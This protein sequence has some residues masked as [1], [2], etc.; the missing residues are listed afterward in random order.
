[1]IRRESK[2]TVCHIPTNLIIIIIIK[3]HH[4]HLS[5]LARGATGVGSPESLTQSWKLPTSPNVIRL[6]RLRSP[7]HRTCSFG[8]VQWAQRS[9]FPNILELY[10]DVINS[11]IKIVV[12]FKVADSSANSSFPG[13]FRPMFGQQFEV[14]NSSTLGILALDLPSFDERLTTKMGCKKDSL[15]LFSSSRSSKSNQQKH[16]NRRF[17][18][19]KSCLSPDSLITR[20]RSTVQAH[21]LGEWDWLRSDWWI[22]CP[23]FA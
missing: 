8:S 6:S 14:R 2:I 19:F 11:F 10:D 12:I 22:D 3:I 18:V 9:K 4:C 13:F 7:Y 23:F 20:C 15:M 21:L 16:Q 17:K 5:L 1:M